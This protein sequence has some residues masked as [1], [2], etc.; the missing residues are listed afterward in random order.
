MSSNF[1]HL[2]EFMTDCGMQWPTRK[3][4]IIYL[5][6]VK[7]KNYKKIWFD[8]HFAQVRLVNFPKNAAVKH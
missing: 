2:K 7:K 6:S 8:L 5:I 1:Q 4:N 3:F